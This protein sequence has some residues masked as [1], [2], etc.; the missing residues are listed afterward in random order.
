VVSNAARGLFVLI[1]VF[2]LAPH[3]PRLHFRIAELRPF[4]R[5]GLRA[6][7]SGVLFHAYRNADYFFVGRSL[8]VDVLSFF[9]A[10]DVVAIIA[11]DR[12]LPA[13]PAIQVLCWAALLRGLALLFPPLF[14]AAGRPEYGVYEALLSLV[15]LVGGF[16]FALEIYGDAFGMMAVCFVWIAAYPPLLL[17]DLRWASR[18]GV[19]ARRVLS[20]A[21]PVLGGLMS[22]CV[23]LALV[24]LLRARGVAP[25]AMIIAL[26]VVGLVA[27]ATYL[28]FV[29][30][31]RWDDLR[32]RSVDGPVQS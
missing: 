10:E 30:K 6:M 4:L 25:G 20:A 8:G 28:R 12:W 15:I 18:V 24:S 11:H 19:S 1:V 29:L 22:M 16:L 21:L 31:V 14:Q 5:F 26:A 17:V 2:A 23:P 27:Y 3:W 9:A 32:S 13:V 7:T